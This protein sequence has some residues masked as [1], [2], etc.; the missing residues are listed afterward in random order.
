[1]AGSTWATI[2]DPAPSL[3]SLQACAFALKENVELLTGQRGPVTQYSVQQQVL[4]IKNA[5]SNGTTSITARITQIYDATVNLN[6]SQSL[7]T[8]IT[9]VTAEVD[10]ARQGQPSLSARIT[11][12]DQS[13]INGDNALA[14]SITTLTSTVNTN[15]T[16]INASL[17]SEATTRAS[18]DSALSSSI[19]TVNASV[20]SISANG[21]VSL[22]ATAAP[23]GASAAYTWELSAGGVSCGMTAIAKVG[24]GGAIAF[25][26]TSFTLTD[27]GTATPVFSYSS[28]VFTFNVPVSITTA[29]I[30]NLAVTNAKIGSLAVAN[31]NMQNAAATQG[32]S[33]TS[34]GQTAFATLATR[35]TG[36]VAVFCQFTGSPGNLYL[37]P[38][39]GSLQ[40]YIDGV[41]VSAITNSYSPAFVGSTQYTNYLE[42]TLVYVT[43]L[44]VGSHTFEV[45]DSNPTGLGGVTVVALELSK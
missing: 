9:E 43:S 16:N 30:A 23:G 41:L 24:G 11:Q 20:N 2:P 42:T 21:N 13:R 36:S 3:P 34:S 33:G 37:P 4:D 18:S 31:G 45:F 8:F 29:N 25:T 19:T 22:V 35:G 44:A 26:A 27:S 12:V 40:L 14:Q 38:S 10:N 17:T 6:N 32:A 1:M 28:G 5:I 15:N 39:V 7:A